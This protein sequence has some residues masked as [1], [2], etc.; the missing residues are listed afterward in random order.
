MTL[1]DQIQSFIYSILI[2]M[3]YTLVWSLFNRIFYRFKRTFFRLFFE[4]ILF[5]VFGFVYYYLLFHINYGILSIYH[6]LGLL[7]GLIIYQMFYAPKFLLFFEK[8]IDSI[9]R[10]LKPIKVAFNKGFAIIKTRIKEFFKKIFKRMK[11]VKK[12]EKTTL[13]KKKSVDNSKSRNDSFNWDFPV[14]R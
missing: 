12:S 7:I 3:L 8:L 11:K 2:G 9:K 14:H 1:N 5:A 13:Q 10:L 6:P 4:V